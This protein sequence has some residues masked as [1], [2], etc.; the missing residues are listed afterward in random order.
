MPNP[1]R[2]WNIKDPPDPEDLDVDDGFRGPPD[3]FEPDA[4]EYDDD[5]AGDVE[6]FADGE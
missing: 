4:S 5:L 6:R 2:S 3:D 1:Y